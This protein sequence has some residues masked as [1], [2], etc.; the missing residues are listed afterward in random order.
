MSVA[1]PTLRSSSLVRPAALSPASSASSL[2]RLTHLAT[3]AGTGALLSALSALESLGPVAGP[4]A[5]GLCVAAGEALPLLPTQPFLI[6]AGALLGA[7]RGVALGTAFSLAG[8]A[9]TYLLGALWKNRLEQAIAGVE[10]GGEAGKETEEAKKT[11]LSSSSSSS[12]LSPAS[13]LARLHATLPPDAS[14]LTQALAVVSLRAI[15]GMPSP[16]LNALLPLAGVRPLAFA[17]GTLPWSLFSAVLYAPLGEVLVALAHGGAS[18]A[19][20]GASLAKAAAD[21]SQKLRGPLLAA[22][23]AVLLV[24]AASWASSRGRRGNRE[25]EQ[26]RT[27]ETNE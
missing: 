3:E 8:G 6:L 20:V 5:L 9:A 25:N 2:S 10:S 15:P 17:A 4:L 14:A 11:P 12:P 27:E 22:A 1:S 19:E 7:K 26:G 13:L 16:V 24:A 18:P 21:A 23:A